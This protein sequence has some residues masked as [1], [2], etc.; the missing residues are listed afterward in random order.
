[1]PKQ[2]V[3]NTFL[4]SLGT[5][6][7]SYDFVIYATLTPYLARVFFPQSNIVSTL[8]VLLIFALAYVVRPLGGIIFGFIGDRWGRKL[9]LRLAINLM[10][11]ATLSIS[12]LPTY[13]HIGFLSPILLLICRI[14]QG[15]SYGIE[16]PGAVTFVCEHADKT[17]RGMQASFI[18]FGAAC[19]FLMA[20]AINYGL[21]SII[22]ETQMFTVGWRIPFFLGGLLG[23]VSYFF[24]RHVTETPEFLKISF[25]PE[26]FPLWILVTQHSMQI[27]RGFSFCLFPACLMLFYLVLPSYLGQSLGYPQHEIYRAMTIGFACS[28]ILLPFFGKLGDHVGKKRLLIIT[29]L[30]SMPLLYMMFLQIST[31][32]SGWLII[33]TITY[34]SLIAA[35]AACY[36]ALLTELFPASVRYS[37]VAFTYN[38]AYTTAAFFPLFIHAT[39]TSNTLPSTVYMLL[40]LPIAGATFLLNLWPFNAHSMETH[41]LNTTKT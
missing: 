2:Q 24:R 19:G 36:P 8:E 33:F 3:K 40:F 16:L 22:S 15:L 32:Q 29:Q 41:A 31:M 7:E 18:F 9:S 5:A 21:T 34:Q 25:R 10:A 13:T 1:M 30:I 27:I 37:G 11:I 38:L 14:C 12:L 28:A 26:K 39:V 35:F 17:K 4:A 20:S 6:L 23:F